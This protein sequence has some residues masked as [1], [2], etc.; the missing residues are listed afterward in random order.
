MNS[1]ESHGFIQSTSMCEKKREIE[2]KI[3]SRWPAE[4]TKSC[5]SS[6]N[7]SFK[8]AQIFTFDFLLLIKTANK[9]CKNVEKKKINL[10]FFVDVAKKIVLNE[11]KKLK[12][13]LQKP[14]VQ[15]SSKFQ[16]FPFLQNFFQIC[17]IFF[18]N[19]VYFSIFLFKDI[20]LFHISGEIKILSI[21]AD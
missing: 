8:D 15:V 18:A 3:F 1:C 9:I 4:E 12:I 14:R 2:L 13:I 11:K 5:C 7:L 20:S 19:F 16:F 17:L 21:F 6:L 10:F